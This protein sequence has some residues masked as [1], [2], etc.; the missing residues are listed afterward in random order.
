MKSAEKALGCQLMYFLYIRV[1]T[2]GLLTM[3]FAK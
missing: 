1:A 2:R 3:L